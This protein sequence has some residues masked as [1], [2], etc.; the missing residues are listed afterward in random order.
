MSWRR[1]MDNPDIIFFDLDHTL[2]DADCEWAWKHML[3]DMGLVPESQ[4]ARQDN[5]IELHAEG[6]TPA[7]EYLEF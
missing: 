6:E 3:A 7:E 2:I 1:E 4:R 5:Y